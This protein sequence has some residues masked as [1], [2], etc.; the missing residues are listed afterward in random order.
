MTTSKSAYAHAQIHNTQSNNTS[1]HSE[2]DNKLTNCPAVYL[3]MSGF[4]DW[5][6]G[7][8]FSKSTLQKATEVREVG[9]QEIVLC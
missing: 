3:A 8:R 1:M 9:S 4:V 5:K 7:S 2:Q 6:G